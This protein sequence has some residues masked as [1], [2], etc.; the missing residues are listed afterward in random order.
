MSLMSSMLSG[1]NLIHDL[2]YMNLD[3]SFSPELLVLCD[4]LLD[5]L[6]PFRQEISCDELDVGLSVMNEVGP[7]GHFLTHDHTLDN[8]KQVRYSDIFNNSKDPC[9]ESATAKINRK[10]IDIIENYKGSLV[11]DEKRKIIEQFEEEWKNRFVN[12]IQG[13]K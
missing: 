13:Y 5:M 11:S 10:T 6:V 12:N 2:G 8:Y 3:S 9:S 4:E 1:A 7:G